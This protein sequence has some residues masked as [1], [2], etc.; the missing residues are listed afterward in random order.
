MDGLK[1]TLKRLWPRLRLRTILF[2]TL[3]FVAALPLVGIVF[4]RIYES[5]LV[6]QT[7]SELIVQGAVIGAA[8]AD[9]LSPL[10]AIHPGIDLEEI[11]NPLEPQ[12]SLSNDAILPDRPP[13]RLTRRQ[14]DR[15]AEAAA[16]RIAPMMFQAT[17]TTLAG[18]RVLDRHGIVVA[19]REEVGMSLAHVPEVASALAG[20][21]R[22][23][24]RLKGG[25][26]Q[27]YPFEWL[28]RASAIRVFHAQPV[29]VDGKVVGAV[30]LARSPRSLFRGLYDDMDK[31]ALGGGLIVVIVI[32]VAGLLGRSITRPV[33]Q[34]AGAMGRVASGQRSVPRTPVT[35]AVEIQS[36]FDNFREMEARIDE[37]STYIRDFAAAVSHEFKTPL[38][39][40][41]GAIELLAE[42]GA[43]M[44]EAERARFLANISA[45]ADRLNLLVSRLLELAR[46]DMAHA[47]AGED[48][49]P[50]EI[51]RRLGVAASGADAVAA[52]PA[53]ALE[54]VLSGLI[55]NSR[56][57]GAR[58]IEVRV[59]AD[60]DVTV[61]VIDDGPGIPPGDRDRVFEAFFTTRRADGGTGLGLPIARSL[62][63]AYGG[64][65]SLLPSDNGAAFRIT[66]LPST[67]AR[68]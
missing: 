63:R 20:R 25:Y 18:V 49:R 8:Y 52:I 58:A 53:G 62:L 32:A 30:L 47:G 7:E 39:A 21:P 61:D 44:D 35:A 17:R 9:A 51:A 45:D 5:T 37:R 4:F 26:E 22:S 67:A 2:G 31:I 24:L 11:F 29:T 34:L 60:E 38:T 19:G 48:C 54:T 59:A 64:A 46:A 50:L 3:L 57:H 6:R 12:T 56:Q 33:E 16:A 10:P 23:T 1:R 28:S 43:E 55:G 40:I 66:L 65:L 13:A 42:H 27:R 36:L 14:P 15:A 68:E 41:R